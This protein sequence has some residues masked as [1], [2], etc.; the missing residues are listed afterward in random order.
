VSELRHSELNGGGYI[1]LAR[2]IGPNRD[3]LTAAL[4]DFFRYQVSAVRTEV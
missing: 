3:R 4:L 2:H 1:I